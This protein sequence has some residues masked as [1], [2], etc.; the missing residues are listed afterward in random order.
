M[1]KN[2]FFILIE[3]FLGNLWWWIIKNI[4]YYQYIIILTGGKIIKLVKKMKNLRTCI[5]VLEKILIIISVLSF[6]PTSLMVFGPKNYIFSKTEI[7][8]YNDVLN[9]S[10]ECKSY[11][12]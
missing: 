2:R 12:T 6:I 5:I 11:I 9:F 8:T 10:T 1:S 7:D 4:K 3:I